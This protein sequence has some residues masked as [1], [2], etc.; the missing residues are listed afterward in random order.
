[1]QSKEYPIIYT[2]DN[3]IVVDKESEIYKQFVTDGV[4]IYEPSEFRNKI[5]DKDIKEHIKTKVHKII[6]SEKHIE[7]SD[8][9]LIKFEEDIDNVSILNKWI[10]KLNSIGLSAES[11]DS[12]TDKYWS[13]YLSG[14]K[15]A[16]AKGTFTEEDAW[17]IYVAGFQANEEKKKPLLD[18]KICI[19]SLQPKY[20]SVELEME[21]D[22]SRVSEEDGSLWGASIDWKPKIVNNHVVI[23]KLNKL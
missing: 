2:T 14:Y 22:Y 16:Q 10:H 11:I 23:V 21:E 5:I 3:V 4:K 19:E 7:N 8:I 17:K 12:I 6:A 18:F 15:A 13:Y 1:M 20:K 9:S